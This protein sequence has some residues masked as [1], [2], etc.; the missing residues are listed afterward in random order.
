MVIA[1]ADA[2]H[3]AKVVKNIDGKIIT[4]KGF[5]SISTKKL[6]NISTRKP[7][8]KNLDYSKLSADKMI[9]VSKDKSALRQAKKTLKKHTYKNVKKDSKGYYYTKT[10]YTKK[11]YIKKYTYKTTKIKSSWFYR[12]W[13]GKKYRTIKRKTPVYAY[14]KV[15][16]TKVYRLKSDTVASLKVTKRAS[17]KIK[18]VDPRFKKYRWLRYLPKITKTV[19]NNTYTVKTVNQK[20]LYKKATKIVKDR[21]AK[22]NGYKT[23]TLTSIKVA[24]PKPKN[25]SYWQSRNYKPKYTTKKGHF[26]EVKRK[27]IRELI[28][29]NHDAK[30]GKGYGS[31]AISS[32]SNLYINNAA[33]LNDH[34]N[35]AAKG[36]LF[37]RSKG[38]IINNAGSISGKDISMIS[39]NGKFLNKS[40]IQKVNLKAYNGSGYT[41][42]IAA[43]GIVKAAGNL[44]I[45][46]KK[47]ITFEASKAKAGK[48]AALIS[49]AG[50]IKFTAKKLKG[51]TGSK[52][53]YAETFRHKTSA[54]TAGRSV[55]LKAKKDIGLEAA[56]IK[57]KGDTLVLDAGRDIKSTALNDSNYNYFYSRKKSGRIF[58]K[59]TVRKNQE[60]REKVKST[61]LTGSS[62]AA[63]AK[64]DV[65]LDATK[66][67]SHTGSMLVKSKRD[68]D[69]IAHKYIND[70]KTYYKKTK[71]FLGFKYS[72]RKDTSVLREE[73]YKDSTLL[74]NKDLSVISGR[75]LNIVGSKLKAVNNINLY[76]KDTLN[77]SNAINRELKEEQH[78]RSGIGLG[79]HLYASIDDLKGHIHETIKGSAIQAGNTVRIDAGTANIIGSEILGANGVGITAR[80]GGV[81]ILAA[82]ANNRDYSMHEELTVDFMNI[83]K[84]GLTF[85][86]GTLKLTLASADYDKL[87]KDTISQQAVGSVIRTNGGDVAIDSAE[88]IA[89]IGSSINTALRD[90]D[91]VL[92]ANGDVLL[93]A[94]KDLLITNANELTIDNTKHTHGEAELSL[95][96][97]N[98]AYE[99][100][101]AAKALKAAKKQVVEAK[102]AY[103]T[104]K[105]N[106][107]KYAAQ[108]AKLK[109]DYKQKKPGVTLSDIKELESYIKEAKGDKKWY[110]TNITAATLN[111]ASKTTLLAQQ[112]AAAAQSTSTYGFNVGLQLDIDATKT[113]TQT[114]SSKSVGSTI[115]GKNVT[116]I[117]GDGAI[118]KGSGVI[119]TEDLGIAANT[120]DLLASQDTSKTDSDTSHGHIT[121]SMMLIGS[122]SV[123]ASYDKSSHSETQ[124]IHNNAVLQAN[125]VQIVTTRDMSVEG[126][127]IHGRKSAMVDVGGD[128]TFASVQD[129]ATSKDRSRGISAGIST[130]GGSL[131]GLNGGANFSN[132]RSYTRQTVVASLTSSGTL[133]VA[134]GGH[135]ELVGATIAAVDDEGKDTGK[136]VFSTGSFDYA[137]LRDVERNSATSGGITANVQVAPAGL[138]ATSGSE[139]INY[140]N[141]SDYKV[142]KTL[143]TI[144]QGI[145]T[146]GG[147]AHDDSRLNRDTAGINKELFDLSRSQGNIDLTVDNRM[148]TDDGRKQIKEDV[149]RTE[150]LATSIANLVEDSISLIGDRANGE[151]GLLNHIDEDQKYFTASKKFVNDPANKEN[152]A[153]LTNP[154]ATPEQKQ[155]AYTALASY[156]AGEMGVTPA[157]AK[158]MVDR[159]YSGAFHRDGEAGTIYINDLKQDTS[160]EAV[161]TTGHETAHSIDYQRDQDVVKTANYDA[162]RDNHSEI[163]GDHTENYMEYQY[164]SN[165]YNPLSSVNNA[166]TGIAASAYDVDSLI[167]QNTRDF[168]AIDRSELD[169]R[170]L[171]SKERDF[172]ANHAAAYAKAHGIS[173]AEAKKLLTMAGEGLVDAGGVLGNFFVSVATKVE[174]KDIYE[175]QKYLLA[176]SKG[177]TYNNKF[178]DFDGEAQEGLFDASFGGIFLTYD[179]DKQA[180]GQILDTAFWGAVEA[181]AGKLL[182]KGWKAFTY[183]KGGKYLVEVY[184]HGKRKVYEVTKGQWDKIR[185]VVRIPH[186]GSIHP[187]PTLNKN[188]EETMSYI[189]NGE[190]PPKPLGYK[191]N[192]KYNKWGV[193]Y[194]NDTK[195]LPTVDKSGNPITYREYRVR[196]PQ[197]DE[198]VHRVVV[199]SDGKCYY[200]NTHY[201]DTIERDGSGIPFYEVGKLPKGTTENIFK[202]KK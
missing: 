100:Y 67:I 32:G 95:V 52:N 80:T 154:N 82:I 193:E 196:T 46:T 163:M 15:P 113:N 23:K 173:E 155:R 126:A 145:F 28:K 141:N 101:N 198:N 166:H 194:R 170:K 40:D 122:A 116:L 17:K 48:H 54:L 111:L 35:L 182:S 37:I 50:N 1:G 129:V 41:S 169:F 159:R 133:D 199:G 201:G 125:N 161:N 57:A 195:T 132:G 13:T 76:A 85:S 29:E 69:I 117:A 140:A 43:K 164:A 61:V 177:Q 86:N 148:F 114:D 165:G 172:I 26:V 167:M 153:A 144:G 128:L 71:S 108:L 21:Y 60:L 158:L 91:N 58:K 131:S 188:I 30:E 162:N 6:Q 68:T 187:D 24:K 120:L 2:K 103:D 55:V 7:R 56:S 4:K 12:M 93:K 38:D 147:E 107:K 124:S 64:R 157:Q 97:K 149:K 185:G 119:A 89:I 115:S 112:T 92:Q 136:M 33:V 65:K 59:I 19:S 62:V 22:N 106:L 18:V 49:K 75:N 44:R 104:Y 10:T 11:K 63:L 179:P 175:A 36:D 151:T 3:D 79:G 88:G 78:M 178:K 98:Q 130:S 150:I 27:G 34:A 105:S 137:D 139:T 202:D 142:D 135:T 121:A 200:S 186:M 51:Y 134:V 160:A 171:S 143:A 72:N 31:A 39:K 8:T 152:V 14:K 176:Q 127:N 77:I 184:E 73:L 70:K 25:M 123:N 183:T 81:N 189:M 102:K 109:D 20:E 5:I 47:D 190:K 74:S 83:L 181:G 84:G 87:D 94:E 118:I 138:D 45:E 9:D 168:R 156:I 180:Q 66:A 146:V 174:Y 53:N 191:P 90:A 99:V 110:L 96:V 16:K 42:A 192:P 197:G